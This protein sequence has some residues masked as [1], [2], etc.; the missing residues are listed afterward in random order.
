MYH[1]LSYVEN[2]MRIPLKLK[3]SNNSTTEYV[4]GKESQSVEKTGLRHWPLQLCSPQ[5][6]NG[7]KCLASDEVM[8]K[9]CCVYVHWNSV[10]LWKHPVLHGNVDGAGSPSF[11]KISQAQTNKYLVI[12]LSGGIP[13]SWSFR[14]LEQNGHEV[15]R[16]SGYGGMGDTGQRLYG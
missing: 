3:I 6:R 9:R 1:Q 11:S 15:C 14:S 5:L 8:K 10:H 4:E 13:K 16:E 2:K 12:L 7:K